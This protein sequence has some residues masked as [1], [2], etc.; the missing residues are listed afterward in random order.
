[1]RAAEAGGEL[2]AARA[3]VAEARAHLAARREELRLAAV[4]EVL[5][6]QVERDHR[7]VAA[8]P[9]LRR[10]EG[11]FAAFTRHRYRLRVGA[12]GELVAVEAESGAER[13]LEQLS[14]GT[15]AQLLLAARVAFATHH[16]GEEPLP[17]MLDEALSVADPDRFAAVAAALLEL[18][19]AGRQVF[20]LTANPDDVARW[21]AVCRKAGADPPQVVDLAAVRTGGA[22][23]QSTDLAAPREAEPVPAPEGL[24]PEAYGAR[25]GV[26]R[27]DPAR[28]GAVHL[29]HLL[30]H[31]LPLLHRLLTGPRL[32]TVG[33]WR[34][35]RDTGGDAGLG[36]GE[37]ARLDALCDLA[38]AA[39]AASRVGR[40]RPVDRA[41][42]E[43]SGAVS[44][45]YL[46]PLAAV[47]AE[48]GGD[49]RA[50]L[51][52]LAR[53]KDDPRT[54]GF[55]TDKRQLLEEYLRQEGYLDERPPLDAEGLRL[56]LLAELG[57]ALEA[58]RLTPEEVARFADTWHAL[59]SP[60]P[61]PAP[62]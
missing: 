47:A 50:L 51:A 26:A 48:V 6:A 10:A 18:A 3:A 38:E 1:V 55:R 42:L 25:L 60:T 24:T 5:L 34:T 33:Q 9:L 17:L 45:R 20:Y 44:R 28:P 23:L 57:P 36:P 46:E 15:R 37:A 14:D 8:P 21:A 27:P 7:S 2:E 13:T 29:F 59:L 39:C 32:A 31:D 40:G 56:R 16:E 54:R 22:A 12:E 19:A 52:R 49:A 35:L 43:Q 4:A 53:P 61:A 41:A 11:W 62:A 58:G 30:R